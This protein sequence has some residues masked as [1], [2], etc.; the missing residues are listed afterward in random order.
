MCWNSKGN[1]NT[2][3]RLLLLKFF[4]AEQKIAEKFILCVLYSTYKN[5]S[6]SPPARK[7]IESGVCLVDFRSLLQKQEFKYRN[8]NFKEQFCLPK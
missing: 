4:F 1:Q 2:F 7:M 6:F 8:Q 3:I 5:C